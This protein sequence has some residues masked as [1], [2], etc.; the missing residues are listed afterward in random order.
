M[1]NRYAGDVGDFG[2]LGMLRFIANAGLKIGVNWFLSD[3]K[4]ESFNNDGKYTRYLEKSSFQN[5]DDDLN[6]SLRNV[7]E[8][9]RS[10]AAI[11][12]ARPIPDA[13][14]YSV[15]L[16]P[17]NVPSFSR[18]MWYQDSLKVFADSDI[19]FCDPDN[20]L[21]VKSVSINS[22]K[23]DKYVTEN[24]L[25]IYYLSGKSVIF[26]NHRSREK[27]DVFFQRFEPLKRRH[28]L[29]TAKWK[30]LKYPR[31][32]TRY[33]FFIIQPDH[34]DKVNGA[35]ERLMRS[36]WNSHFLTVKF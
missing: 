18:K 16:R 28:E 27:E 22:I 23:S 20:G 19:V 17:G 5:C 4:E 15:I 24:E 13:H 21:L 31:G 30:A 32:T 29:D 2:K 36:N 14:Y 35:L 10:V 6:K 12:G 11:E 1:Q 8:G 3:R 33:F 7:V 26:Y 9:K 34:F 25:V